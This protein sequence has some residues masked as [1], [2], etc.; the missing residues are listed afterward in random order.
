[1]NLKMGEHYQFSPLILLYI[2]CVEIREIA[3]NLMKRVD[4][5]HKLAIELFVLKPDSKLW[6]LNY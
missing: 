3:R 6:S 4:D 2:P 1:M 5:V